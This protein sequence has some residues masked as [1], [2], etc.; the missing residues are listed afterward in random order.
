V[1]LDELR[2]WKTKVARS[3][4]WVIRYFDPRTG[5]RKQRSA[6]T[7]NER[8]AEQMLGQLRAEL[9]NGQL[10]NRGSVSWKA[11]RQ[12]YTD[13]V[14]PSLAINTQSKIDTVFDAIERELNPS[15]LRELSSDRVSYFQARLREAGLAESTIGLPALC[16]RF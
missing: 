11:F 4:H 5:R 7:T 9:L 16:R 15:R 2:I 1:P 3:P 14:L 6:G 13:E 10:K 8:K 12:K